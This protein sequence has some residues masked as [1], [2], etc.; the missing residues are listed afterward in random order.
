M[1]HSFGILRSASDPCPRF[2]TL[3]SF[4]LYQTVVWFAVENRVLLPSQN[5]EY[6][7]KQ[8]VSEEFILKQSLKLFRKKSY[9]NTSMADIAEACGLLKGSIYHYFPSKE[10]LM[11]EVIESVHHYFSKEVLSI[12]YDSNLNPQER[13]E[14]MFKQFSKVFL[15]EESGDFMGNI[16]V[17]TAWVIPEF[18][19]QI[20][21]FFT[22]WIQA[23]EN[24]Y[25]QITGEHEARLLAEQTVAEI[26]GAVMMTRIFKNP[27]FLK[28]A[29]QRI[30]D[31][32]ASFMINEAENIKRAE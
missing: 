24:I 20:Q 12:A 27:K 16:G 17:E 26:E 32:F 9:H 7:P 30:I 15:A 11:K 2:T 18:A 10:A 14:T 29:Y 31:R 23:Q 4:P 22:D 6:L 1:P 3:L 28:N 8:K 19:E 21:K 25:L 5:T 13:I